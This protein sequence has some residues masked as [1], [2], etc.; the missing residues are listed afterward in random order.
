MKIKVKEQLNFQELINFIY[1]NNIKNGEYPSDDNGYL[2]NTVWVDHYVI[3]F[4]GDSYI[5]KDDTWTIEREVEITKNTELPIVL[6]NY[7]ECFLSYYDTTIKDLE[8]RFISSVYGI[9]TIHLINNDSTHTLI[10]KD[11]ELV[12]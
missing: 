6:V 9:E 12:E 11:G 1:E 8:K 3:E 4:N 7:G 2:I 10:Y 5:R